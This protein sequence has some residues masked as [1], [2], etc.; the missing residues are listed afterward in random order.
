MDV[1]YPFSAIRGIVFAPF[2]IVG[3]TYL[4]ATFTGT[5]VNLIVACSTNFFHFMHPNELFSRSDKLSAA[6]ARLYSGEQLLNVLLRVSLN[7]LV[8]S[9]M[10]ALL[11]RSSFGRKAALASALLSQPL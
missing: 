10:N 1:F 3:A 4:Y 5:G 9:S 8:C 2:I 11:R 7:L 6:R